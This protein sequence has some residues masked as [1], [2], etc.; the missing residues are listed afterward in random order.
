MRRVFDPDIEEW[1]IPESWISDAR[2]PDP[3]S[4]FEFDDAQDAARSLVNLLGDMWLARQA[5]QEVYLEIRC[6][7]ADLI[8]RVARVAKP[9]GVPVYSGGGMDGLK[10]KKEA[11]RRA[12]QREVPTLVGH[13]TDYDK[14]GGTIHDVF[15]KDVAAFARWHQ[16]YQG[17]AGAIEVIRLGLT[18]E[19]ALEHKL[20]DDDGK[21]E[22]DGLP[23]PVLDA[24][25]RTWIESHMDL[26][27]LERVNRAEPKMRAEAAKIALQLLQ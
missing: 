4:P 5:G 9:Y 1:L 6:E 27:I 20:L 16:D 2:G 23:V 14:Y 21:A 10:V 18:L 24:I 3:S 26:E 15:A 19:Q 7:A 12:A 25:V 13:L 17:V 11:A 8:A 22:L